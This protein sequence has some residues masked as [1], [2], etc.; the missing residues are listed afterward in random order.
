MI[1]LGDVLETIKTL[2]RRFGYVGEREAEAGYRVYTKKFDRV[3][4]ARELIDEC[5]PSLA[6]GR[7]V[8]E[9]YDDF[10]KLTHVWRLQASVAA[11]EA[12][13]RIHT[14]HSKDKLE[15]MVV[16]LLVDHSGSM[17]D[18]KILLAMAAISVATDFLANLGVKVEILGFTT[19][20]WQGGV[21]RRVWLSRGKPRHPGRLCDLLHIVY[22]EADSTVPGA[23]RSLAAMLLPGLLKENVDGEAIQWA[24]ERLRERPERQKALI[25]L[26]DG[27]PVDDSTLYENGGG[28]LWKHLVSVLS[29][30]NTKG[31]IMIAGLGIHYAS[32]APF[33][34]SVEIR[35]PDDLQG[36]LIELLE[37]VVGCPSSNS[38]R[39]QTHYR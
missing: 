15:D 37:K 2:L 3:A 28:Y 39:Q 4:T 38:S 35:T 16:A 21:S 33:Q 32:K 10:L 8:Y 13:S 31:E 20:S 26:S 29:G 12:D 5:G 25:V 1:K 14:Q 24:L 7:T 17:R 11:L 18:Q 27:A 23:P 9:L 30:E 34:L 22:R 19:T 6:D 36:A